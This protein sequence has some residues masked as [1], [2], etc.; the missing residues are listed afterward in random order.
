M[1]YFDQGNAVCANMQGLPFK[2]VLRAIFPSTLYLTFI[3]LG[4]KKSQKNLI[5]LLVRILIKISF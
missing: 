3:L 4:Q 1:V 5:K 2:A